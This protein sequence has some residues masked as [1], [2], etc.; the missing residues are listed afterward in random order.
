MGTPGRDIRKPGWHVCAEQEQLPYP[1]NSQDQDQDTGIPNGTD[2][3]RGK[4]LRE[5]DERGRCWLLVR[6]VRA[7]LFRN[8]IDMQGNNTGLATMHIEA[9]TEDLRLN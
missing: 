8:S 4:E 2:E 9:W 3:T 7:R 6:T 1:V 5:V